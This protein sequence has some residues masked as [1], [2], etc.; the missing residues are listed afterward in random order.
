M[1]DPLIS[2]IIPALNEENALPA[3]LEAV[4]RQDAAV[5]VIVVDGGSSDRTVEIASEQRVTVVRS[6][7]G[8]GLQLAEG[9]RVA[10]GSV[11]WFLHADTCPPADAVS[12]IH[13]A[14]ECAS[15]AG[16]NFRLVFDGES[17]SARTLT[18]IY[19]R[20]RYLGLSYGDSGLFVRREVYQRMGGFRPYPLFEDLDF[21][22]RLRQ[23][24][25][26]IHVDTPLV[27]SSRR[28]E[29][30]SFAA[31]FARWTMLQV[32]FWVGVSPWWL[33]RFYPHLRG[34]RPTP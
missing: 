15:V 8:R 9:A 2:I 25:R 3:T 18:W 7:P 11:L 32:L 31:T 34:R 19:P 24:G 33:A 30:R 13:R 23:Q 5:E 22:G 28:F 4:C 27:T 26:F 12:A 29:G 14:L 10:R 16:G 21:V 1:A 20:L 17:P 6:G